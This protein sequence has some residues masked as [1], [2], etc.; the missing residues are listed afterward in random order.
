MLNRRQFLAA[1]TLAVAGCRQAATSSAPVAGLTL[2]DDE[3]ARIALEAEARR[4]YLLELEPFRI[5]SSELRKT[6]PPPEEITAAIPELKSQT[7]VTMR[8]H[9]RY[10]ADAAPDASKLG[11]QFLW[12]AGNPLPLC[13][14]AKIP[15]TPVLQLRE[16]D[17]APQVVF[18]PGSDLLQLFWTARDPVGG[19]LPAKIV[20]PMRAAVINQKLMEFKPNE[21]A[22]P[23]LVP[24]PCR[25][26]P[27]MVNELPDW[28]T[29]SRTDLRAKLEAWK[30]AASKLS[31]AAY[32]TR[33]LA[34]ARG[35]KVGGW[36]RASLT[37]PAC[38][39]CKHAMDYLLTV[40]TSEW[41][42]DDASR[43]RPIQEDDDALGRRAACG[44]GITGGTAVEVY[45][46][47]RCEDWP[48]RAM[49]K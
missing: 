49:V 25:F 11:G 17:R 44:L 27:E 10:G 24:V 16:L 35:T 12:P 43:W 30:P 1:S 14:I 7:R 3:R 39:T 4:K 28:E 26:L 8:L 22:F 42:P 46:C 21:F 33:Y 15:M 45:V 9:P 5:G 38:K 41:S 19:E 32:Y 36:P 40:D 23:S 2:T 20:W 18:S 37:A 48:V 34:A 13:P 6:P 47:R 31:P 29:L